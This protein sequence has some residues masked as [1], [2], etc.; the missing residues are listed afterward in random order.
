MKTY[1]FT[2][3]IEKDKETGLYIGI[4]PS[5]PGAHTQAATLDELQ[6]NLREVIELCLEELNPDELNDLPEFI[7]FQQI[8]I[9]V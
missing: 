1:Q 5:L 8:S 3:Q 9:A 7:G 6:T 2:A 4:V